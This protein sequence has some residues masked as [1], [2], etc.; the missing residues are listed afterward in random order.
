MN[1]ARS[2]CSTRSVAPGEPIMA[3]FRSLVERAFGRLAAGIDAQGLVLTQPRAAGTVPRP[4]AISDRAHLSRPI[5]CRVLAK[6][7]VRETLKS[8]LTPAAVAGL[9]SG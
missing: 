4:N 6:S 8:L 1:S 5:V 3:S 9:P 7:G 2:C